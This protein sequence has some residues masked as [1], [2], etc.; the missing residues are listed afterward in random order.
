MW[1]DQCLR[2]FMVH[3][4]EKSAQNKKKN[5]KKIVLNIQE[6]WK[7]VNLIVFELCSE[8]AVQRCS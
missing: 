8:A 4:D 1:K 3:I 2:L 7:I 5:F 6:L